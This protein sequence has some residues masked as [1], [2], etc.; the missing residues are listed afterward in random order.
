M[1]KSPRITTLERVGHREVIS[2]E[3]SVVKETVF[4]VDKYH[5]EGTGRLHFKS[6]ALK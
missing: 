6:L 5:S 3:N 4:V 2:L 1:L